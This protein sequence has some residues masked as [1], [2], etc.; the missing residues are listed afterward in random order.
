MLVAK[1]GLPDGPLHER[2]QPGDVLI[3]V[4]GSFVN[5]DDLEVVLD[6]KVGR[7]V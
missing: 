6:Q 5:F 7:G 3:K 2:L 1:T 4:N